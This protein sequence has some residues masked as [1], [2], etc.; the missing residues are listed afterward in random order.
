MS[1]GNKTALKTRDCFVF[2]TVLHHQQDKVTLKQVFCP[3]YQ[4]L[5]DHFCE[6]TH[7]WHNFSFQSIEQYISQIFKKVLDILGTW[8]LLLMDYQFYCKA[9]ILFYYLLNNFI[10]AVSSNNVL[11]ILFHKENT[12]LLDWFELDFIS[13]YKGGERKI[14]K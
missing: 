13:P 12:Q 4:F 7:W 6:E 5:A 9:C 8:T 2:M 3:I 14:L 11:Y 1:L 10:R